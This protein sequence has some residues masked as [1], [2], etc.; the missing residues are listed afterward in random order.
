MAA[1]ALVTFL[2]STLDG[3]AFALFVVP[4]GVALATVAGLVRAAVRRMAALATWRRVQAATGS[5]PAG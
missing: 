2:P 1:L 3:P 4:L 5:D